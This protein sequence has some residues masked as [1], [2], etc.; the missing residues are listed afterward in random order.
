MRLSNYITN[1]ISEGY[2]KH[3]VKK[4]LLDAVRQWKYEPAIK[5]GVRVK[6]WKEETIRINID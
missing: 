2:S 6:V 4:A 5:S 1:A 3:E